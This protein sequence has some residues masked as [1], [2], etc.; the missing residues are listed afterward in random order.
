MAMITN[1]SKLQLDIAHTAST[2][3]T[4]DK[5]KMM[6]HFH[7]HYDKGDLTGTRDTQKNLV[8][9]NLQMWYLLLH[10]FYTNSAH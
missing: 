5:Y 3:L 8:D 2:A 9:K 6:Q 10:M 1:I 7:S 4:P